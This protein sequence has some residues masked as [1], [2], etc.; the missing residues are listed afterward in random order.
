MSDKQPAV[1]FLGFSKATISS[2]ELS[3]KFLPLEL[4]LA[5]SLLLMASDPDS[6]RDK[7]SALP[8]LRGGRGLLLLRLRYKKPLKL[9]R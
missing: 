6:Y 9:R 1:S 7:T 2:F 4:W 8:L 5:K 3:L